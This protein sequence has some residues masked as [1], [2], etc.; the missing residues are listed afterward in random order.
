MLRSQEEM[1]PARYYYPVLR[2]LEIKIAEKLEYL[3]KLDKK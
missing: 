2:G 1:S 3:K